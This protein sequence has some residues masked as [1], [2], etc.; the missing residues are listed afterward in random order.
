MS[1]D[2][3]FDMVCVSAFAS[4]DLWLLSTKTPFVQSFYLLEH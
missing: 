2:L 1:L 3:C 4:D